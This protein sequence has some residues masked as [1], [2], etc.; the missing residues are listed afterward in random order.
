MSRIL[1][2]KYKKDDLKSYD[3]TMSTINSQITRKSSE[4]FKNIRRFVRWNSRH[5]EHH[6]GGLGIKG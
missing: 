2:A 3:R 6:P 1:E 5:V 4:S